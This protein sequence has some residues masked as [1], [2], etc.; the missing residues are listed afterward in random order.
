MEI[1]KE[2]KDKIKKA[3]EVA[4]EYFKKHPEA[5]LLGMELMFE[6]TQKAIKEHFDKM[7]PDKQVKLINKLREINCQLD[8]E[9]V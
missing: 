1:T 6:D 3:C 5:I 2:Q 9:Q 4:G 7:P 8:E